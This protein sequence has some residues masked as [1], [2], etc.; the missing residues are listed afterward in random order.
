M[1]HQLNHFRERNKNQPR[2]ST[3]ATHYCVRREKERKTAILSKYIKGIQVRSYVTLIWNFCSKSN[4]N[5]N[6][7]KRKMSRYTPC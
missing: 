1:T 2:L 7:G 4:T 5:T 6:H 3:H